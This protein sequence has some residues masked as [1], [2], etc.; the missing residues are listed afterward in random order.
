MSFPPVTKLLQAKD[1]TPIYA[2]AIGDPSKPSIVLIHGTTLTA[3]IFDNLFSD[4]KLLETFYM[5]LRRGRSFTSLA[6]HGQTS[7]QGECSFYSIASTTVSVDICAPL[8]PL[9][10]SGVVQVAP[11]PYTGEAFIVRTGTPNVMAMIPGILLQD[12][13]GLFKRTRLEFIDS[14][15]LDPSKVPDSLKWSWIGLGLVESHDDGYFAT[16]SPQNP[17]KFFEHGSRGLPLLCMY[18]TADK[19]M[20]GH[21]AAAEMQPHFPKMRI[22]RVEGGSHALFYD[23]QEEF[24]PIKVSI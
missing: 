22:V 12:D 18:G 21:V 1:D 20:N 23:Y 6:G 15:F 10:I 16:Y 19:L 8:D 9:P 2:E 17:A 4:S 13:V 3:H 11:L 7:I 14:M 5:V 24:V